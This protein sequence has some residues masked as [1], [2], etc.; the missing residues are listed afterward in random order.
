M[1]RCSVIYEQ[2]IAQYRHQCFLLMTLCNC[3]LASSGH[4]VA[5]PPDPFLMKA[6]PKENIC[7]LF[8]EWDTGVHDYCLVFIKFHARRLS[9]SNSKS[10]TLITKNI[11]SCEKYSPP[12]VSATGSR[13]VQILKLCLA[14][15][16]SV[17]IQTSGSLLRANLLLRGILGDHV[18]RIATG[19]RYLSARSASTLASYPLL[20]HSIPSHFWTPIRPLHTFISAWL[21]GNYI[22]NWLY[23][24]D[25]N[26]DSF[27]FV[28]DLIALDPSTA[29]LTSAATIS[30]PNPTL[31][32]FACKYAWVLQ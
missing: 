23:S 17:Y 1:D 5:S 30:T 7:R 16:S 9:Q 22:S 12:A 8:A 3:G 19:L 13:P 32:V 15:T 14:A 24:W 20:F 10:K 21:R 18:P 2:S 6:S 4:S 28:W 27:H 25:A 31:Y 26:V 11:Q 29:D